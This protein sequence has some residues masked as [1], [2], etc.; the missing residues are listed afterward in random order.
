M[1]LVDDL[2]IYRIISTVYLSPDGETAITYGI[3]AYA[4][5]RVELFADIAVDRAAVEALVAILAAE[6]VA[7]CHFREVVL[8][9]IEDL[10]SGNR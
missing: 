8:D 3:E 1:E 9:Y 7:L 4:R 5:G 2:A 6:R 10:A